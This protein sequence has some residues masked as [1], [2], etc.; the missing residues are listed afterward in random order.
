M[1]TSK[2]MHA[3]A[4]YEAKVLPTIARFPMTL[5]YFQSLPPQPRPAPLELKLTTNFQDGALLTIHTLLVCLF[6]PSQSP[7][8]QC[9]MYPK[10][11][12]L[13]FNIHG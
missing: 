5:S 7:L 12:P 13:V 1:H 6:R 4:L 10:D 8:N 2:N 3:K 9:T 11:Y